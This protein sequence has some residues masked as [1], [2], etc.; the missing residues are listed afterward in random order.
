M[1]PIIQFKVKKRIEVDTQW[2]SEYPR[3]WS[4]GA[5]IRNRRVEL[6]NMELSPIHKQRKR[7]IVPK[8]PP[9][10][11]KPMP[12]FKDESKAYEDLLRVQTYNGGNTHKK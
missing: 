11:D 8:L 5:Q 1:K 3:S 12:D 7:N 4:Q 6:M 2:I 10:N 9:L